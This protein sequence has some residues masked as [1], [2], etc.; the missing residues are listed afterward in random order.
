[1][2]GTDINQDSLKN[3]QNILDQNEDLSSVIQLKSQPD[4]DYILYQYHLVRKTDSLLPC[5]PP[6]HDS[7]ESAMKG[8]IRKKK[9]LVNQKNETSS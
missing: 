5:N 2:L 6:F 8:N 1:M 3:A 7:E 4:A 9:I